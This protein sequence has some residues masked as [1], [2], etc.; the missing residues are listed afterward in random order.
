MGFFSVL[1]MMKDTN[2]STVCLLL[3][4]NKL[5][6]YLA[7]GINCVDCLHFSDNYYTS[8]STLVNDFKVWHNYKCISN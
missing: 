3:I 5:L 8:K 2:A 6:S 4:R 7:Y 1:K